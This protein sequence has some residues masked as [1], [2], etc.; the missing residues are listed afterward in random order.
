MEDFWTTT[1]MGPGE[2]TTILCMMTPNEGTWPELRNNCSLFIS[3]CPVEL[4]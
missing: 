4:N 1:T 2:T 3:A